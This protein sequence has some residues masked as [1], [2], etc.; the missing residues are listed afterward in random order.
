MQNWD[1]KKS[2]FTSKMKVVRYQG[3]DEN[4]FTNS[5]ERAPY[6]KAR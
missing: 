3:E 6:V 1:A 5:G 2:R 4:F